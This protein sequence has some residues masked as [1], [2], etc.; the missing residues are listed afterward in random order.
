MPAATTLIVKLRNRIPSGEGPM[1]IRS[2]LDSATV[3]TI[4]P[5]F[6]GDPEAELATL[7]EVTLRPR[8]SVDGAIAALK[9]HPR[10]QYAH[11]PQERTLQS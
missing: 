11:S 1:L 10:I 3:D 2:I 4:Q 7:F 6:P 8:A 9:K 5:L